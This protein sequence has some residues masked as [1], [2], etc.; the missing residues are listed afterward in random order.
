VD[1]SFDVQVNTTVQA[2]ESG[3]DHGGEIQ[4]TEY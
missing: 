2:G 1:T 4:P 3:R